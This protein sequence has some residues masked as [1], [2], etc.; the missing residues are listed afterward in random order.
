MCAE[1]M[2]QLLGKVLSLNSK[3]NIFERASTG[4]II[5]CK[6]RLYATVFDIASA[7]KKS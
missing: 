6:A 1:K 7:T 2:I 5:N 3:L 4:Y